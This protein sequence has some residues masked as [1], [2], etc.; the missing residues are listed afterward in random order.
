MLVEAAV[1]HRGRRQVVVLVIDREGGVSL[2]DCERVTRAAGAAIE[3]R[4]LVPGAYVLEVSSPGI[5]R[6]LKS[7]REF[8]VFRG[9]P[10]RVRLGD[11]G[12]RDFVEITGTCDGSRDGERVAVRTDGGDE[13]VMAWAEVVR[14]RLEPAA[15]AR[16][17]G[18]GK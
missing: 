16:S 17:E 6:V 13:T 10:V 3:A 12:A 15:P 9:K 18:R 2:G 11:P 5:D 7:P 4:G 1:A 14:A 8:D